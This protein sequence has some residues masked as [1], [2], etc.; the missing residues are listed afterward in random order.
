MRWNKLI[1]FLFIP[2][3]SLGGEGFISAKIDGYVSPA[4]KCQE[5]N[6]VT[7]SEIVTDEP[8]LYQ[9]CLASICQNTPT[10]TDGE[11]QL[12]DNYIQIADDLDQRLINP[13]VNEVLEKSKEKALAALENLN[14]QQQREALDNF[15]Y[16]LADDFAREAIA[17]YMYEIYERVENGIENGSIH[18][19]S[20]HVEINQEI[21][22]V[23][24][25]QYGEEFADAYHSV[26]RGNSQRRQRAQI[27]AESFLA[28]VADQETAITLLETRINAFPDRF[29]Y[30]KSNLLSLLSG[31]KADQNTGTRKVISQVTLDKLTFE[32]IAAEMQIQ[33][34]SLPSLR[35]SLIVSFRNVLQSMNTGENGNGE[36]AI[37]QQPLKEQLRHLLN[38]IFELKQV[39]C[40][41]S[42]QS[43]ITQLLDSS[44]M[45]VQQAHIHRAKVQFINQL[46]QSRLYSNETLRR[47]R[48]YLVALTIK[49]PPS[50][51]EYMDILKE[52]SNRT[53]ELMSRS[54]A[55]Y[56]NTA[57][58]GSA[59]SQCGIV[60]SHDSSDHY[61]HGRSLEE[62][63]I[64]LSNH[65]LIN[66]ESVGK[67][68]FFHE[69]SHAV[70]HYIQL[71]AGSNRS[72]NE[73]TKRKKC[74]AFGHFQGSA[75]ERM[76]SSPDL[77]F[78]EEDYSD[79]LYTSLFPQS[80]NLGCNLLMNGMPTTRD[81]NATTSFTQVAGRR[82]RHSSSVYR[83]LNIHL[84]QN[85]S[86]S[87]NCTRSM[88]QE[89]VGFTFP[90]T[91]FE[92]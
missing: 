62:R 44:T 9:S 83:V 65:S 69:L 23:L 18:Q 51:E 63:N 29:P 48:D 71:D 85:R 64:Y 12:T 59:E 5:T 70:S 58:S 89:N 26:S 39:N 72:K 52:N 80:T 55:F 6:Q 56:F 50:H 67:N 54:D 30:E 1:L 91:C 92:D 86:L 15:Y 40:R 43:E 28:N 24:T 60:P 41:E 21:H 47:L 35:G 32:V 20:Y 27:Q 16:Q 17:P 79:T 14:E 36:N 46:I 76:F 19:S 33:N 84:N 49:T 82:R 45:Q 74:L 78:A 34:Q 68:I 81:R 25:S 75:L 11:N 66:F 22:Q 90:T 87:N 38:R 8:T 3:I 7:S 4:T 88:R 31:Y 10:L 61:N 37:D 73:H 53:D 2:S 13:F 77:Q 57:L 42:I